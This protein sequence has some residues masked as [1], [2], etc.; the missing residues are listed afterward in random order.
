MEFAW[1]ILSEEPSTD[2]AKLAAM[3]HSVGAIEAVLFGMRNA[4][5]SAVIA[6]DGTYA[7]QGLS[8]VLTNS[9]G[10]APGK[11]RA[12]FLDL[13]RAQGAQGDEPLDLTTIESF[14]YSDRTF[15]TISKM[16][17]SD[18]AS[19]AMVGETFHTPITSKFPLNGWD[20]KTES[21]GYQHVCRIVLPFSMQKSVAVLKLTIWLR[22]FGVLT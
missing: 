18:F 20:R 4:N 7:F 3:G 10:Y 19:F 16:H 9:Y 5:V 2:K 1:S 13:R 11:M 12:A 8:T 21:P 15:V 14:R 17:H 22:R 6:L